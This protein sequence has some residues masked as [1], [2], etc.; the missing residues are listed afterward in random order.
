MSSYY[1]ELLTRRLIHVNIFF[2]LTAS[3]VIG[4]YFIGSCK[5]NYHTITG[6]TAPATKYKLNVKIKCRISTRRILV[7]KTQLFLLKSTL[8]YIVF[9]LA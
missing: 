9:F 7:L 5:F 1:P 8:L 4:T 6:T 2:E 3:V